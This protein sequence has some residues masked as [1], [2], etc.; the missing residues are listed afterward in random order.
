MS[1]A[2]DIKSKYIVKKKNHKF[3]HDNR[4]KLN[5][6]LQAEVSKVDAIYRV[7]NTNDVSIS[8][9][10]RL[11]EHVVSLNYLLERKIK[12]SNMEKS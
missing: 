2:G 1:N 4:I 8:E 3:S 7:I 10:R 6:N 11:K 12:E 5:R 9:L